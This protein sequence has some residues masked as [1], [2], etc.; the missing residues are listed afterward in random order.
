[1]GAPGETDFGLA[2]RARNRSRKP[3]RPEQEFQPQATEKSE[4]PSPSLRDHEIHFSMGW[5]SGWVGVGDREIRTTLTEFARPR[6]PV[7]DGVGQWVGVGDGLTRAAALEYCLLNARS[8]TDRSGTQAASPACASPM[9][10]TMRDETVCG[11]LV[12]LRATNSG[13][14][15]SVPAAGIA[16][17]TSVLLEAQEVCL[18]TAH[19]YPQRAS[20]HFSTWDRFPSPRG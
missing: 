20:Q 16:T 7:F 9:S 12:A 18:F 4:P 2:W 5:G 6:N 1:M 14:G 17:P 11:F 19:T 3:N 15:F 13:R 10:P 8:L